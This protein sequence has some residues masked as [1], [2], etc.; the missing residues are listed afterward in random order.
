VPD[1][2]TITL[3]GEVPETELGTFPPVVVPPQFGLVS[4]GTPQKLAINSSGDAL[5]ANDG[6]TVL[7]WNPTSQAYVERLYLLGLG[8]WIEF[9]TEGN[10][11]PVNPTPE[12]GEAFFY[13]NSGGEISWTRTFN[14]D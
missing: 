1:P 5:P 3:V 8:G 14:V 7:F 4:Q 12:V 2:V 11:V 10:P 9:D 13:N 6:D